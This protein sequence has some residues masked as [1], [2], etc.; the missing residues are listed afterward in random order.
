[1]FG[2]TYRS[3]AP[4]GLGY[5]C[6]FPLT[7]LPHLAPR[8]FPL[9]Y[10]ENLYQVLETRKPTFLRLVGSSNAER[11]GTLATPVRT[12]LLYLFPT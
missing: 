9:R 5:C 12:K 3:G 7:P 2:R 8:R 11:G 1:M 4:Q 10:V 6:S